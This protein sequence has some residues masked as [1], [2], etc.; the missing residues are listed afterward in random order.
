MSVLKFTYF[1][2][3]SA[4]A[5]LDAKYVSVL[6]RRTVVKHI[7]NM[8]VMMTF[9]LAVPLLAVAIMCDTVFN[10]ATV[11]LLLERFSTAC[12]K[13]GLDAANI[14]QQFWNSFSLSDREVAGCV[15]IALGFVSIFWSLFAFD[16]IADVYGQFAGGL[17]T[18]VPLLVPSMTSYFIMRRYEQRERSTISRR[19]TDNIELGEIANPVILPQRTNDDFSETAI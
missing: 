8:G 6:G 3:P 9:G 10:L 5:L 4:A 17:A 7:L 1:D 13:N 18:L 11:L 12:E 19:T 15:H 14:N 2:N 16:W